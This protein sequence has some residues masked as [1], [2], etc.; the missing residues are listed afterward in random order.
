MTLGVYVFCIYTTSYQTLS[1]HMAWRHAST[2][3]IGARAASQFLGPDDET[4]RLS[5][6]V[7]PEIA[8]L[9][10]VSLLLLE[11]MAKSGASYLLISAASKVWGRFVITALDV[12]H[13][14]LLKDGT[15]AKIEFT[16]ELKRVEE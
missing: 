6:V 10:A 4:V 15:P 1:R 3:R 5:G 9:G 12:T 8:K 14:E 11:Q 16:I 2:A 7:Y 13:T